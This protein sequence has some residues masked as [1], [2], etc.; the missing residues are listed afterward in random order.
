M[1]APYY[2]DDLVTLHL[3][4]S[5]EE[6]AWTAADV[7]VTD[8]PYGIGWRRSA[9]PARSS[10]AHA[11]IMGDADTTA[12]DAAV[13][14]MASKPA[15]VFGSLYA[16]FPAPLTQVLIWRKPPDA[17][18]VGSTTGFRRDVEAVFLVG[19][20]PRRDARWSSV[21]I[22]GIRNIGTPNSPAGRTGHP[23]AKPMDLME[24]ILDA[25]PPGVIADPFAGSGSTLVAARNLGRRAIGVECHEPYAE[26]IAKRLAQS[27]LDLGSI[28]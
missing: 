12:R 11:G 26:V 27:V 21:L 16:P 4:D 18:V 10:R 1:S 2:T 19:P 5:L 15:V 9:N 24:T 25:C 20:W 13:A 23:H 14:L 22:S 28:A 7:L 17:G 6:I 3:G 8:P